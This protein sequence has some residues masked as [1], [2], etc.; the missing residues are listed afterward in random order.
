MFNI[1]VLVKIFERSPYVSKAALFISRVKSSGK[2]HSDVD[3]ALYGDLSTTEFERVVKEL[4]DLTIA[5]KFDVVAYDLIKDTQ[6]REII[7]NTGLTVY[8]KDDA[9]FTIPSEDEVNIWQFSQIDGDMQD[10]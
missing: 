10:I 8:V 9:D 6:M 2:E 3:I 1:G 5:R 4:D 7:D